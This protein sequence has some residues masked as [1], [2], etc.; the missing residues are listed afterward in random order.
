MF[1]DPGGAAEH[2]GSMY[3]MTDYKSKVHNIYFTAN[4]MATNR[5]RVFGS[6]IYNK[7]EATLDEVVMPDVEDRLIDSEGNPSLENALL[8]YPNMDEYSDLDYGLLNLSLG[9]EYR[10]LPH[11]VFSADGAYADLTDDGLYVFGDESGSYFFVR[12]GLRVDF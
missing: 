4:F 1:N 2:Y 11:V 8:T 7:S 3:T 5:L 6:V 9:F 12:T 10:I